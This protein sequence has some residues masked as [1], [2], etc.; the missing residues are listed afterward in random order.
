ML[1]FQVLNN[2]KYGVH[3]NIDILEI[4]LQLDKQKG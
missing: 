4:H 2:Y 1:N 3:F